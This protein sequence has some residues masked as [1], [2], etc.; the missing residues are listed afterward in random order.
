MHQVFGY[1]LMFIW[2][3]VLGAWADGRVGFGHAV[4]AGLVFS[5]VVGVPFVWKYGLLALLPDLTIVKRKPPN[6]A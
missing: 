5:A 2:M 1:T 4:F 6:D 3:A